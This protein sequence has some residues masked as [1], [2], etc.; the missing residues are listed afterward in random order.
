MRSADWQ[1]NAT[2]S[3]PGERGIGPKWM[4]YREEPVNQGAHVRLR[5]PLIGHTSCPSSIGAVWGQKRTHSNSADIPD[6]LP[7]LTRLGR[8]C[9]QAPLTR[10]FWH[11]AAFDPAL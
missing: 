7:P 4:V 8:R 10:W 1:W 2:P 9:Y 6:H 5:W 11:G 3:V